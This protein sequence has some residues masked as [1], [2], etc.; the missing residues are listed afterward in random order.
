M[1]H[2]LHNLVWGPALIG[3]LLA[4]GIY[5]TWKSGFFQ[6][7]G[8][9]IWW[10]ATAGSLWG[11]GAD[12]GSGAEGAEKPETR[13][14]ADAGKK[15]IVRDGM[16]GSVKTTARNDVAGR[17]KADERTSAAGEENGAGLTK[18][19]TAC[20][21]LAATIGTGNIAGVAT[22]LVAG[23]PGAIFWMWVSALLGMMTAYAEVSLGIR[24]RRRQPDGSWLGGS[25]AYLSEGLHMPRLALV[26]G[27]LCLC[28]SLGMGSMVQSNAVSQTFSASLGIPS[29]VSA[30]TVTALVLGIV[31][32]GAKRIAKVTVWMIP[33]AAAVYIAGSVAVLAVCRRQIPR[34]LGE[35]FRCALTPRAALGGAGGYGVMRALRQYAGNGAGGAFSAFRYGVA[36]GVFSNEAGLGT[37]AGLHGAAGDT[38]PG[39]QGMWAMFEVF[40]DTLV[41][42]TMTAL[43]ILCVVGGGE[44]LSGC[45]WDGAALAGRCFGRILGPAGEYLVSAA[46]AVFAFSTMIAWYFLGRQTLG[47]V[48]SL[49]GRLWESRGGRG[50]QGAAAGRQRPDLR[51]E[52]GMNGTAG[53]VSAAGYM[54]ESI[55]LLLYVYAVFLGCVSSLTSVWELSDVFNGLMAFPNLL[56][57]FLLRRDV[58]LR[59][60]SELDG[61]SRPDRA[62]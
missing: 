35:I 3:L 30:V 10:R 42:C 45:R 57:L 36:R 28:A 14:G 4:A 60:R 53:A 41:I 2:W 61:T 33:L 15:P 11:N 38:T 8:F 6:I 9:R 32:G 43:V 24:F 26:Y 16:S 27:I 58:P 59:R 54:A 47:A 19:Q 44:G 56:A 22:A 62:G 48:V 51:H 31:L 25:C 7:R 1:I 39:E 37:L 46:M 18:F 17:R 55:Y 21:A 5:Y 29:L 49:A 50:K 20:T 52:T 13:A 34:I 40:F 23:G 12:A